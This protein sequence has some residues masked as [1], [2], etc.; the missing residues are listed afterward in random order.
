M[1]LWA[2][3]MLCNSKA[4]AISNRKPICRM[5][6]GFLINR[7]AFSTGSLCLCIGIEQKLTVTGNNDSMG[8]SEFFLRIR[9][10]QD[11]NFL[12]SFPTKEGLEP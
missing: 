9:V 6:R 12:S 3:L 4:L 7:Y 5:P 11:Y 8:M 10:R 1:W 2:F